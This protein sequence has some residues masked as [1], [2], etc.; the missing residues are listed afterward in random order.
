M[1]FPGINWY[2]E[3]PIPSNPLDKIFT[4]FAISTSLT[5]FVTNNTRK[6]NILDLVLS[7]DDCIFNL[8]I[9]NPFSYNTSTSD[10]L[11]ITANIFNTNVI[12]MKS[13]NNSNCNFNYSLCNL[14]IVRQ[15]L[16]N[17]SWSSILKV[18][19]STDVLLTTFIEIV[20]TLIN[21]NSPYQLYGHLNFLNSSKILIRN[22]RNYIKININQ[23]LKLNGDYIK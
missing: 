9:D 21:D 7:N 2:G 19:E 16:N 13:K 17:L 6:D 20:K 3:S 14:N 11:S 23:I 15:T 5:Q 1:N 18:E 4:D 10:H 12:T 22:V 8:S